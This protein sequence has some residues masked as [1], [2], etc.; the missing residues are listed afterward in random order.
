MPPLTGR[1]AVG[2]SPRRALP[3]GG[4]DTRRIETWPPDALRAL[5]ISVD[6]KAST[7]RDAVRLSA[8]IDL[9]LHNCAAAAAKLEE[10]LRLRKSDAYLLNDA[11]VAH[12]CLARDSPNDAGPSLV[13]ALERALA[14]SELQPEWPEPQFNLAVAHQALGLRSLER[15]ALRRQMERDH[16]DVW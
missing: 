10:S 9:Y 7:A 1:L 8:A 5:H 11:A 3:E 12:L 2:A 14:A 4:F 16:D 6:S 13:R 15:D